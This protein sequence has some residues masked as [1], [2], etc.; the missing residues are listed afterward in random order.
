MKCEH[1]TKNY[2]GDIEQESRV[3]MMCYQTGY[4]MIKN[5]G[6]IMNIYKFDELVQKMN[7]KHPKIFALDS[8]NPPSTREIK[9]LEEYY[10]IEFPNSYKEFL[11]RYGGGYFAFTVV[12]SMDKKSSFFIKDNIKAEFINE[13]HF[14]PVI[15]FETGDMIGFKIEDK[16]CKELMALYNHEE[17][18]LSDLNK[19]LFEVLAKYG[20]KI[21]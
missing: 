15:D 1:Q 6:V 2:I 19:D 4:M 9:E 7:N 20:L 17:R 3:R 18:I 8:D 11:L 21:D 13:N 16:K 10:D 14:I 12:Y 5:K